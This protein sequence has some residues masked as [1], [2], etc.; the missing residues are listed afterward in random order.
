M[1]TLPELANPIATGSPRAPTPNRRENPS[2]AASR[3]LEVIYHQER[4][5]LIRYLRRSAGSDAAPDLAQE[6]FLRAAASGQLPHLINPAGFLYRI[7]RNMLIDRSRRMRCRYEPL[8]LIEAHDA[9]VAAEQEYGI[10]ADDLQAA[11][12]MALTSLPL[13]T[14]QIF[15]M[16]RSEEKTYHEIRHELGISIAT[17]EY[18]MMKALACIRHAIDASR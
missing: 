2:S 16:N 12:E 18:H 15:I 8:S 7:A 9:P 3:L 10:E 11:Y 14:R 1:A 17:V 4:T 6:V 5:G 13:R